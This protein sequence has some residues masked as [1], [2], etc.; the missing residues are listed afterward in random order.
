M[1][2]LVTAVVAT[3]LVTAH[4]QRQAAK[5]QSEELEKQAEQ[6][7]IAAE[8]RELERRQRLN[9]ILAANVVSQAASGITGEGTPQSIALESAKQASISEGINALSDR[10]KQAQLR[11]QARNVR[12][13]GNIQAAS[14]ML[15]TA[16]SALQL[17]DD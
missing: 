2:W 9:K 3:G 13:A 12:S 1:T 7:R 5:V 10:L 4:G 8:S 6:E 16:S 14:I 11:R 17:G 15:N